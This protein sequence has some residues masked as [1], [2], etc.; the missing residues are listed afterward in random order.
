VAYQP[1]DRCGRSGLRRAPVSN[2]PSAMMLTRSFA[3]RPYFD[4]KAGCAIAS[5]SDLETTE[6]TPSVASRVRRGRQTAA[7]SALR[8]RLRADTCLSPRPGGQSNRGKP[9]LDKTCANVSLLAPPGASP[10][11]FCPARLA[12]G[13]PSKSLKRWCPGAESNHRHRDFQSSLLNV[14]RCLRY[15]F[16]I[17]D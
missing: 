9:P 3:A 4:A 11:S 8:N 12:H 5:A 15:S 14:L 6:E 7:G 1:T 17:Q 10:S 13:I 2:H 16:T